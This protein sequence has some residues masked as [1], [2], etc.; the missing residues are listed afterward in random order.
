[1]LTGCHD[2]T[3]DGV[4][5]VTNYVTIEILGDQE[6]IIELG[7]NYVDAGVIAT[8]GDKD[9]TGSVVSKSNVNENEPGFYEVTY[10]A[11]NVDGFPAS[12]TRTVIVYNPAITTDLS[13]EYLTVSGTH[14]LTFATGATT[15]YSGYPVIIEQYLP[16]IF[17]V[18]DLF[19][20]YYYP[21]LEASGYG[22]IHTMTGYISL[23]SDNTIKLCSSHVA[24][25]GDGLDD[26][27]DGIYD[28][29]TGQITW[30]AEY[31]SLFSFNI[32]LKK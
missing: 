27:A 10:S 19:G 14:R 20:G 32:V 16:G 17:Y 30:G 25:W 31:A 13:G 23:G 29:V 26:L 24:G 28:P 7:N 18:S 11:V 5:F 2:I 15:A 12:V 3:T 22:L 4:T 8:E 6:T 9:V 1:M 21:R